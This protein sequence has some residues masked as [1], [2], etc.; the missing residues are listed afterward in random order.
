MTSPLQPIKCADTPSHTLAISIVPWL[1]AGH[2]CV[3]VRAVCRL[4]LL[5]APSHKQHPLMH[6]PLTFVCAGLPCSH[7]PS[8]LTGCVLAL[9]LQPTFAQHSC[10]D[11]HADPGLPSG[12]YPVDLKPN[13]DV[14]FVHCDIRLAAGGRAYSATISQPQNSSLPM[15]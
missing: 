9:A 12:V 7:R 15:A 14:L 5:D 6:F 8:S 3:C 4:P 1:R 11:L 10:T 2:C 13:S